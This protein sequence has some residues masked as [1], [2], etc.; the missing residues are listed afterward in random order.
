MRKLGKQIK[1]SA[2]CLG[3]R[4]PLQYSGPKDPNR[5][6]ENRDFRDV[7][8]VKLNGK[9]IMRYRP[10]FTQWQLDFS[11]QLD[12][13]MMNEDVLVSIARDTGQYI[14]LGDYRPRFGTF[15]IEVV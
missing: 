3:D 8:G 7:R 11:I 15:S 2:L 5:M 6:F 9:R 1:R 4:I 14:G 10:K 12:E 13:E